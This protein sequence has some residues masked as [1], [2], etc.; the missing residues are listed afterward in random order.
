MTVEL[1]WRAD[2]AAA[3]PPLLLLNSLGTST[4]VWSPVL[5]PLL[6]RF[7]VIRV[8]H[9]GHGNSPAAP[10][11]AP[12]SLG[13]L[14]DDV[15]A[16]LDRLGLSRVHV[17]GLSLGAMVAMQLAISRP[18]RVQRLAVLS[19]SPRLGPESF[20]NARAAAARSGGTASIAPGV[21][22]R[23]V[24]PELAAR[25]ADLMTDLR[26][27]L[28][29]VDDESYAQCCEAIATM[30]LRPD[31]GRIAAPTLVVAGA[32]DSAVPD[33][34]GPELAA[35]ITGARFVR[36]AVAAHLATVEQPG[37]VAALLVE[38]LA[39][40]PGRAGDQMRRAVLG[41]EHVEHAAASTSP[42]TAPL[43]D[44]I[45]R[46]AWGEVWTRPGLG[47]RE[48]SIATLTAL[49]TLGAENE[50]AL[51]V[52]GALNNG[53]RADEIAEVL[54]HAAVY[55]GVP[56]ANRAFAIARAVIESEIVAGDHL[57]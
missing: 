50:L 14:A 40:D 11:D 12:H 56:R 51:H 32:A 55:A 33:A 41:D 18:E 13:D 15:C 30:D 22:A 39:R 48:R 10:A 52:R 4:E 44:L 53:L 6:E 46:Y 26:A 34:D 3:A 43:Q 49:V 36:L 37:A 7:H 20:W 25:N 19:T 57:D 17:A 29:A 16:V 21:V 42:F 23:W 38:H 8:D 9:R 2:G 24:T 27:M 35:A 5:A 47:R 1:A 28:S 54:L 31:L 45:T